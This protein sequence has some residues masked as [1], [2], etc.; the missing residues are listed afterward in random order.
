[1]LILVKGVYPSTPF[2]AEQPCRDGCIRPL[3]P[4]PR[5][6]PA[7]IILLLQLK[8]ISGF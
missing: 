4:F 1:M 5:A 3:A 6:A 7:Q 8:T 2:N